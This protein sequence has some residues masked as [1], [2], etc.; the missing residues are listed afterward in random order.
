MKKLII[1]DKKL[2]L[3]LK[4]QEKYYFVLKSIFQNSNFFMLI[5]WN[6]FVYLKA[7][8]ERN[9]NISTSFRCVYTINRKRF[10]SLAPFSRY[11]FIKLIQSG[12]ISGL[13]KSS[14]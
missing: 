5:R 1:K 9:S 8:G 2:R 12:K 14:W 11:V 10:N 6:A 13:K 3:E 4:K 7:L